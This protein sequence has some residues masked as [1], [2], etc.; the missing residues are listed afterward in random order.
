[1]KKRIF[2]IAIMLFLICFLATG[3]IFALNF[4]INQPKVRVILPPGW[5][6]GGV[7]KVENRAG[8]PIEMRVYV[9]DWVYSDQDGA[10]NFMPPNAHPKSCAEWIKFYPADF[11]I[12]GQGEKKVNYV[13][14]V[15]KD[16]VGGHYAVLFFEVCTGGRWDEA[17]GVMVK[18]YN[19]IGSLFYVEPQGTIERKAQISDFNI[20]VSSEGIETEAVFYNLG[21][22]DITTRGTFDIIDEE[23]F[24]FAR[25]QFNDVY[26][27]PED[28]AKLYA[29]SISSD[30][31]RGKYDVILTFDLLDEV[32]VKEYQIEVSDSGSIVALKE[33]E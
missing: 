21:N 27:M 23:G 3:T 28:K 6:D 15:P 16:A 5:S 2:R 24:V 14:A 8:E 33:I 31:S 25:G 32:L 22:V 4:R 29:K 1:M 30:F 20:R 26:T 18:V 11:T 7:I 10:K 17:K 9:G 13:V 19:R 12:V